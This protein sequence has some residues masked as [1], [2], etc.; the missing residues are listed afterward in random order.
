MHSQTSVLVYAYILLLLIWQL[1]L[2]IWKATQKLKSG[3]DDYFLKQA[4]EGAEFSSRRN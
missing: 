2:L 3:K 4:Q 1:F